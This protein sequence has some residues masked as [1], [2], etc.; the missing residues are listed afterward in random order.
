MNVGSGKSPEAAARETH[1]PQ[2]DGLRCVAFVAVLFHHS[3]VYP[4]V[5][6]W[7]AKA[8]DWGWAG[9]ELFFALSGFLITYLLLK[10]KERF[11]SI[12]IGNFYMRRVLRIW[13]LYFL[14]LTGLALWP[15]TLQHWDQMPMYWTY[16]RKIIVPFFLFSGNYSIIT[17]W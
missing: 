14:L 15:L 12:A 8:C 7:L 11:H 1:F 17:S 2:L 6:K 13:P 16:I 5:S 10:E 3:G 9:V 4:Q